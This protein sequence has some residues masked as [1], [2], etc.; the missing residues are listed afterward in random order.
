MQSTVFGEKIFSRESKGLYLSTMAHIPEKELVK[1]IDHHDGATGYHIRGVAQFAAEFV[2]SNYFG[3]SMEEKKS[4]VRAAALHDIGKNHISNSTLNK[5][6][7]L[8]KKEWHNIEQHP[9]DGFYQC[10]ENFSPTDMLPVLMHH[11]FQKNDY[12]N[13]LIQERVLSDY[14]MPASELDQDL[15]LISS[16]IISVADHLEARYPITKDQKIVKSLRS[17]S[18]RRYSVEEL[19]MLVEASFVEAGKV[20]ALKLDWYFKKLIN[21]SK[22]I[23]L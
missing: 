1:T 2:V 4:I 5:D 7:R 6:G 3:F 15:A 18:D 11:T 13:R 19:P 12:P 14:D 10:S 22:E 8:N 21:Q 9:I 23:L 16:L 20:R 17:Y